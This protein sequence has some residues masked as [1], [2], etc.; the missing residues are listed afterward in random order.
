MKSPWLAP[1]VVA[2]VACLRVAQAQPDE[3]VDKAPPPAADRGRGKKPGDLRD[4]NALKMK[5]VW[6]PPG[7]LTMEEIE[8]ITEPAPEKT[9]DSNAAEADLKDK[10]A[11]RPRKINKITPV[12]VTLTQDFWLGK[13]EVTQS[14]WKEVMKT[15]PWKG[16]PLPKGK[17]GRGAKNEIMKEGADFPATFVT[18]D[19]AV[20]FC[21]KLTEQERKTA[22]LPEEWEYTLP[23]EAQ[24]EYA[25][26]AITETKYNFGDEEWN[27]GDYAWFAGNTT[28]AGE[29]YAHRVGQKAANAWGLFDMHGNV[30]EWCRDSYRHFYEAGEKLPGGRDPEAK[31][32]PRLD[33][34]PG[35]WWGPYRVS[36]G[37]GWLSLPSAC[38]SAYHNGDS[39]SDRYDYVGFRVALSLVR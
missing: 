20:D 3:V 15:E 22:R 31:P 34:M 4:D 8:V 2:A 11:P 19:E 9:D 23:T 17:R 37:G 36:R 25:C 32:D 1:C 6:C 35:R 12:K 29:P 33:E 13:Y 14:E 30:W 39:P 24:W 27:L 10:P 18:W 28:M 7:F 21:C 26:R 38:R 16:D 5:L